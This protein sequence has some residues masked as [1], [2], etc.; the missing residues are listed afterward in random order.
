MEKQKKKGVPLDLVI[1]KLFETI[2][3]QNAYLLKVISFTP[4]VLIGV[5]E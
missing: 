3:L 5:Y 2:S 1:I 4:L